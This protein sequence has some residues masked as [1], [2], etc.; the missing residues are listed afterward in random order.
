MK[1]TMSAQE[2]ADY[3]G[4]SRPTIYKWANY[5][6]LPS[7]QINGRV[8]LFNRTQVDEW[9]RKKAVEINENT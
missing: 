8:R 9:V 5:A 7:K 1:E 3:L 6:K 4:V 2:V